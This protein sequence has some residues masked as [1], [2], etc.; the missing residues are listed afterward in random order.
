MAW[1]RLLIFTSILVYVHAHGRLVHPPNR[2]SLWRLGYNSPPNYDDDGMNCG[3]FYRQY[4]VNRGK[5]GICGDAYDQKQPRPHELGGTYGIGYIVAHYEAGETINTKV[6]LS[7]SHLGFWELRICPDPYH[8][9]QDCFDNGYL[10]E[11]ED[12]GTKYYPR[13]GDGSY[14]VTFRLPERLTCEHCVLQWQYTAGNNWGFCANGTQGLGCGNQEQ[15]YSCADISIGNSLS[16][17]DIDNND[18]VGQ[19]KDVDTVPSKFSALSTIG[20]EFFQNI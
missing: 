19:D 7:T 4:S 9:S 16:S 18:D 1:S 2:A 14:D 12:G 10:L 8:Q 6:H 5:C 13:K 20:E 3:G 17:N 11:L 15:F